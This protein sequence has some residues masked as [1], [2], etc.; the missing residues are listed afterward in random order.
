[1]RRRGQV[2]CGDCVV[3]FGWLGVEKKKA[4]IVGSFL[5]ASMLRVSLARC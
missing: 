2:V 5:Q 1:M 3:C 4:V